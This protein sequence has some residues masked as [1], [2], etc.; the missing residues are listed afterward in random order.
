MQGVKEYDALMEGT[1]QV[2]E[3]T[4][5]GMEGY[6]TILLDYTT[7]IGVDGVTETGDGFLGGCNGCMIYDAED[8]MIV[9]W[10][11]NTWFYAERLTDGSSIDVDDSYCGSSGGSNQCGADFDCGRC[12]YCD[13]GTCRYAGEGPYGCYGGWTPPE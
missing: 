11:N 8:D 5:P 10:F 13:N 2:T 12:W 9:Y 3:C 4:E 6:A 1:W 7:T